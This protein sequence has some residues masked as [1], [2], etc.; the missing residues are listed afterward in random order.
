MQ[1]QADTGL[2]ICH[3]GDGWGRRW[4]PSVWRGGVHHCHAMVGDPGS[5][6]AACRQHRFCQPHVG[7]GRHAC[8]CTCAQEEAHYII[9]LLHCY[10]AFAIGTCC[11][12]VGRVELWLARAPQNERGNTVLQIREYNFTREHHLVC[13]CRLRVRSEPVIHTVMAQK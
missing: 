13:T 3:C 1:G 4:G 7:T 5:C 10:R 6:V 12:W 8:N 9:L 11:A 2:L